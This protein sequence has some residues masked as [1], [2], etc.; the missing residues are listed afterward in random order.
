MPLNTAVFE[1]NNSPSSF[2]TAS[3][4]S[5][6]LSSSPAAPSRRQWGKP[7]S[8][9][10]TSNHSSNTNSNTSNNNNSN[11]KNAWNQVTLKKPPSTTRTTT[12]NDAAATTATNAAARLKGDSTDRTADLTEKF[13]DED[14]LPL[15]QNSNADTIISMDASTKS[16]GS[17]KCNRS[18]NK[19]SKKKKEAAAAAAA[20]L[21]SSSSKNKNDKK[22]N[23][24]GS[25]SSSSSKKRGGSIKKSK[26]KSSKK[27]STTNNYRKSNDKKERFGPEDHFPLEE[28]QYFKVVPPEKRTRGTFDWS[29]VDHNIQQIAANQTKLE[30]R[31]EKLLSKLQMVEQSKDDALRQMK[32]HVQE[33]KDKMDRKKNDLRKQLYELQQGRTYDEMVQ[34]VQEQHD[35]VSSLKK[36][37]TKLRNDTDKLLVQVKNMRVNNIKL[38]AANKQSESVLEQL[39]E[40]KQAVDARYEHLTKVILPPYQERIREMKEAVQ[41]RKLYGRNEHRTKVRYG[42][43]IVRFLDKVDQSEERDSFKEEI[44]NL[45]KDVQS[46][47]LAVIMLDDDDD[48]NNSSSDDSLQDLQSFMATSTTAT[49]TTTATLTVQDSF[50]A[51]ELP[52]VS[53]LRANTSSTID[54]SSSSLQQGR[55]NTSMSKSISKAEDKSLWDRYGSGGGDKN[56]NNNNHSSNNNLDASTSSLSSGGG[57][58]KN[59]LAKHQDILQKAKRD[60]TFN[61]GAVVFSDSSSDDDNDSS[62]DDDDDSSYFS[63]SSNES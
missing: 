35:I 14:K 58:N 16:T 8:F 26:S 22:D 59:Q 10:A 39:K 34:K 61:N 36:S 9:G 15:P 44:W 37:N 17:T 25:S 41:E 51:G 62:S 63:A 46:G 30:K 28:G 48:S 13:Q 42:N 4:S 12:T 45:A 31:K 56:N 53:N 38:E 23:K 1:K 3:T 24:K 50:Q 33:Q 55:G 47:D 2:T 29:H 20:A 40:R 60:A 32:D 21:S 27:T 5:L 7:S 57:N 19:S 18:S 11:N 54:T 49:T 52:S 6:S 43:Y